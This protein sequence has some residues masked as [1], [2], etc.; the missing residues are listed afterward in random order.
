MLF[1]SQA[2]KQIAPQ[3]D[4]MV[5]LGAPNSSNS[6]RLVEVAKSSGCA[7]AVLVQRAHEMDW[8]ELGSL[9]T[10]GITAGA[11]APERIVQ[12]V[13]DA[14]AARYDVKIEEVVTTTEDIRFRLPRVLEDA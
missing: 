2:V 7:R 8:S 11:S 3:C 1:R 4:A 13:I 12:E 14:F 10:L 6:V 9:T 5:V